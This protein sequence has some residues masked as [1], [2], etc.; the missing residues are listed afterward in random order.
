MVARN[1]IPPMRRARLTP[2]LPMLLLA[3]LVSSC[4]SPATSSSIGRSGGAS[5]SQVVNLTGAWSGTATDPLGQVQMF[6]Q[7][8]QS[9]TSVTGTVSANTIVGVPLYAGTITASLTAST[10][11]FRITVPRGSIIELPDCS[12]TL[13][14]SATDLQA[15]S[16][17][18]TYTGEHSC[19]GTVQGGRFLLTKQ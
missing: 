17:A 15:D 3:I 18:G 5:P 10:L 1:E 4:D 19:F 14:G 7:L 11:T 16:M 6:W 9:G 13:T 12:L 2:I 8:T